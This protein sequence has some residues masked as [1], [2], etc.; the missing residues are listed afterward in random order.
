LIQQFEQFIAVSTSGRRR[1][2]SGTRI[3]PNV[4]VG[5]HCVLK[6]LYEYES[7]SGKRLR[8][9]LLHRSSL[10]I[11]QKERNYWSRFYRCFSA[12]LYGQK[13]YFDTYTGAVF[14]ILKTFFNWLQ[15]EKG[16][17]V[18]NFH[19]SF[20][21]PFQQQYPVVLSPERLKFLITNASFEESL[22]VCLRKVKDVF[23]AGCTIGTRFGDLIQLKP[24]NY[25]LTV[26][27]N[28]IQLYTA[29]TGTAVSIPIPQ[30]LI[31]ILSRYRKNTAKQL[32]P[33]LSNSRFNI[34]VK[35]LAEKAGWTEI[36]PKRM[37]RQGKWIELKKENGKSWRFCDHIT[38]HTMRRTAITTLLI[39]GVP[40]LVVRKVSGH[41]PGSKEFYKYVAIAQSYLCNEVQNAHSRLIEL[42]EV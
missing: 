13:G 12:F 23:V 3:S 16:Y 31:T 6:L 4:V 21:T 40:E 5:Y 41:A 8:I 18:G 27:G 1:T 15:K 25:I 33:G 28:F 39:L 24:S 30:Y 32:L 17:S 35:R 7:K 26:S 2:P 9:E 19:L 20:H 37:C 14:K 38:S 22:P 34:Q 10:R 42:N 29:K 11:I 36:L